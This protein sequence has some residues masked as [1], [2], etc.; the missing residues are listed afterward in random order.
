[1]G[2]TGSLGVRSLADGIGILGSAACAL[3]CLA[4]PI[5]LVAGT[6]LPASFSTDESF[7]QMLLWAILPASI[8]AFGLGCWRHKD[9]WVFLLGV[10][11]L[12]GL[13]SSVAAPHDLIGESG[14]RL[15]TVGS[16]GLLIAA[17]LRNFRRCRADG[18]DHEEASG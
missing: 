2:R 3:H 1:M 7:H 16:T 14:E 11:G 9:H 13:S 12:L 10:L 15:L 6:A 18:C 4:A 5:L 17:H 8:L